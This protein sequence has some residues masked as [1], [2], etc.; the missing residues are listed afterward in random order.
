ML[1][2]PV[3]KGGLSLLSNTLPT[4]S[5]ITCLLNGN[6]DCIYIFSMCTSIALT[7][8]EINLFQ[9]SM[10]LVQ[11]FIIFLL[12]LEFEITPPP[13]PLLQKQAFSRLSMQTATHYKSRK[14][15]LIVVKYQLDMLQCFTFSKTGGL[16]SVHA[17]GTA[18]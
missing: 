5:F 13:P 16:I 17:Q 8:K 10:I 11:N 1:R 7:K 4:C 6:Q 2:P 18:V 14:V 12:T 9:F 3:Y 15:K